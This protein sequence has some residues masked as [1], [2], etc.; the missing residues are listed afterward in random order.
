MEHEDQG[1]AEDPDDDEMQLL[2]TKAVLALVIQGEK[3]RMY[4]RYEHH[5]AVK[6]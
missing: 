5:D 4:P 3:I 1:D 6:K 2:V